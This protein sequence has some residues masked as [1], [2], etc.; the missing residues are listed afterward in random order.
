MTGEVRTAATG[1][2]ARSIFAPPLRPTSVGILILITLIAFEEM[3]VAPALPTV[4]RDLHAIGA[5]GWAFTG[6]LVAN[7]VGMVVSGQTSDERGPKAPLAAG[8]LAFIAGLVIAGS[9]VSMGQ[10]VAGRVIQGLGGGLV[11]T[12]MYVVIGQ[13]YPEPTRPK[14][15]AAIS[16]AWVVPSLLGPVVSGAVTQHLGWRWV[17]LGLLPLVI[18]G[19]VLMLP[20]LRSLRSTPASAPAGRAVD[21]R[22]L[23]RVVRALAVAAGIAVLEQ[24]GQHPSALLAVAALAGLAALV[25][26]LRALLPA[27]AARLRTGVPATVALRGVLAGAFFGT[28][29]LV[30]LSL[31]VQHGFG[32]TEAGLP[33]AC[34]GLT[35]ALGSWWQGREVAGEESR[36]RIR[37]ARTGYSCIALAASGIAVSAGTA[38]AGWLSYPSWA[39][40]GLG[41]GLTMSTLSVLLLRY[42]TDADRGTDSAA[43]QLCDVTSSAVTTGIGGA[44]VAAA[45]AGTIGYGQAFVWLDLSM[46]ALAAFGV[47]AAGRLRPPERTSAA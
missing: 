32:A 40:A 23:G 46:A 31:T 36:R 26:G 30:P 29:S 35:W 17:F 25:W 39:L 27:G 45:A 28:E 1:E 3:A 15:F 10:L 9:A 2:D 22:R 37:L 42:T 43:L 12:A 8:M 41:A 14:L 19:C 11:I 13:G 21:G 7:V 44:L 6:F 16:S 4:A 24:A 33:L 20:V 38:G 18:V 34:A 5:Y 47:A